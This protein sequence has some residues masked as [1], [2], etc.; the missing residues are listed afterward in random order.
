[1]MKAQQ[2]RSVDV[3]DLIEYRCSRM[4]VVGVQ[5]P[6]VPHGALGDIVDRDDRPCALH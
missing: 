6:R 4:I 5:Q 1:M 2:D 3:E